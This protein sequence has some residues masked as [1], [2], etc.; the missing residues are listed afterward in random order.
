ARGQYGARCRRID[1]ASRHGRGRI[2]LSGA[3]RGAVRDAGG[4]CP[5]Q[6][7]RGLL[8]VDRGGGGHGVVVGGV[9]GREGDRQGLAE[10]G[11][12]HGPVGDDGRVARGEGRCGRL[13][14]DGG[15]GGHG[16]VVGGVGGR[17]GDRQGLAGAGAQHGPRRGRVD[18]AARHGRGGVELGG[19]QRRPI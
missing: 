19:T 14:V 2:E 4:V 3:Q 18:V 6:D 12:Q 9:G 1:E 17:E 7:R 13:H 15:G 11:G 10:A 8:H 5:G 16:I